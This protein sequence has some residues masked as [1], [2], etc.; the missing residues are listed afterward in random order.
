MRLLPL[1]VNWQQTL[2]HIVIHEEK[3]G[4]AALRCLFTSSVIWFSLRRFTFGR[5]EATTAA[6]SFQPK[7]V[8]DPGGAQTRVKKT[9]KA[10]VAS[11]V[12]LL[13]AS[14]L[15]FSSASMLALLPENQVGGSSLQKPVETQ[16]TQQ[17]TGLPR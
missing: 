2:A 15:A 8:A 4:E 7:P 9:N 13:S 14:M 6:K 12:A 16:S 10:E 17:D 1:Q 3:E 5:R 11:M